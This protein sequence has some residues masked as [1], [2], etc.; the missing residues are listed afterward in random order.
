MSLA[1]VISKDQI[2][3]RL[4]Q[5]WFTS[6]HYVDSEF[7]EVITVCFALPGSTKT[8]SS[9][10]KVRWRLTMGSTRLATV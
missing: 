3:A 4:D 6:L 8:R 7:N 9:P 10:L 2:K 1:H 5:K